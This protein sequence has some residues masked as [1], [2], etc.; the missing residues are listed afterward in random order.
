M[1]FDQVTIGYRN[2]RAETL[3]TISRAPLQTLA[4]P[5]FLSQGGALGAIARLP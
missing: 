1:A 5:Y 3:A 4:G 2:R